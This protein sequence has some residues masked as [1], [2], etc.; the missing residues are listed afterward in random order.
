MSTKDTSPK[1]DIN[2]E[3]IFSILVPLLQISP[4]DITVF[5]YPKRWV[6]FHEIAETLNGEIIYFGEDT[7][8]VHF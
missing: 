3:K 6:C 1:N 4:L 5:F 8:T 7:T 2:L